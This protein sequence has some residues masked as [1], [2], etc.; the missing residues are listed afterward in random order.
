[1]D[2]HIC[3]V[4]YLKAC[5]ILCK[6]AANQE[7]GAS[8]YYSVPKNGYIYVYF[9]SFWILESNGIYPQILSNKIIMFSR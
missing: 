8:R 7:N 6:R 4:K 3:S 9:D 2:I 5:S 1:M